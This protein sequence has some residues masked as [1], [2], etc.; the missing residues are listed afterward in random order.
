[1]KVAFLG[2]SSLA[3]AIATHPQAEMPVLVDKVPQIRL[4]EAFE[5]LREIAAV[6]RAGTPPI[7]FLACLG[8]LAQFSARAT[9]TSNMFA[10][11]GIASVGGEAQS[12]VDDLVAAFKSSGAKLAVLV[13]S[14]RIYESDAEEAARALKDAGADY[15]YLA[16][17]P[18]DMEERLRAA[19]VDTFVHAG[20]NVLDLLH[21]AQA[22][23]GLVHIEEVTA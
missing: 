23:I 6:S 9:W 17:K 2:G 4:S 5:E 16:G 7:V 22:R 3:V 20:C 18:G 14:D 21:E 10:T 15:L 13:S 11:G 12:D 19:G 1:M 8:P